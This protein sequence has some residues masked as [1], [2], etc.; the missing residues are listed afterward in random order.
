MYRIS[1]SLNTFMSKHTSVLP[2]NVTF[3]TFVIC[4]DI[5]SMILKALTTFTTH[6]RIDSSDSWGFGLDVMRLNMR[7]S[8]RRTGSGF[9]TT[10]VQSSLCRYR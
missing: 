5:P 6:L 9:H 1:L 8:T 3:V 7:Q 4:E 2:K 10:L